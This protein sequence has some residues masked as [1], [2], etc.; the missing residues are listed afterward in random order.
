[1]RLRDLL[2]LTLALRASVA[3]AQGTALSFEEAMAFAERTPR[4]E[5]GRLATATLQEAQRRSPALDANP[6]L[7]LAAGGRVAPPG[8]RGFEGALALSQSIGVQGSA[9]LRRDALGAEARWVEAEVSSELTT[10]RLAI[11]LAWLSLREAQEQRTAALREIGNEQEFVR[12]V[13]RLASLGE[14]TRADAAAAQVRLSEAQLRERRAEGEVVDAQWQLAAELGAPPAA[15]LAA[16][17]PMP[18]VPIPSPAQQQ[19]LLRR[20]EQL[21][22]V[23]ARALLARTEALRAQEERALR[24]VR[25][26]VGLEVRHDALNAT[27]LQGTLSMPLPFFAVGDREHAARLAASQRAQGEAADEATRAR[28]LLE[29]A[30]HDVEHTEEVLASLQQGVLPASEEAVTLRQR[31]LSAGEATVLEVLDARHALFEAS[32]ALQRALRDRAWAR[33]R[34]AVLFQAAGGAT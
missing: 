25:L 26:A 3:A 33:I 10:R 24:G 27:V 12:Q 16:A 31:Q 1:M 18:S 28:A 2:L 4:L 21:P 11:A 9:G 30:V 19:A 5:Q 14:R 20:A 17:G 13:G 34:L 29:L 8:E 15:Q 23:R 7:S 6:L 32:R 22:S